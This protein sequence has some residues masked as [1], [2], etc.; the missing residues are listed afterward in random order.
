M[1]RPPSSASLDA[2][3]NLRALLNSSCLQ[4]AEHLRSHRTSAVSTRDRSFQEDSEDNE[5]KPK[6]TSSTSNRHLMTHWPDV[7]TATFSVPLDTSTSVLNHNSSSNIGNAPNNNSIKPLT[8][9]LHFAPATILNLLESQPTST[10][11]N[12]NAA[13]VS[14]LQLFCVAVLPLPA[15]NS[16]LSYSSDAAS[17]DGLTGTN[18]S[19][20]Q[21]S[22]SDRNSS[23][24]NSPYVL[25]LVALQQTLVTRMYRNY[26]PSS[27]NAST[28]GSRSNDAQSQAQYWGALQ[29]LPDHSR[30]R[31]LFTPSSS[32]S[33][34][35]SSSTGV[36]GNN[37]RLQHWYALLADD[38]AFAVTSDTATAS[39]AEDNGSSNKKATAS[40]VYLVQLYAL[41]TNSSNSSNSSNGNNRKVDEEAEDGLQ[42][43]PPVSLFPKNLHY[44]ASKSASTTSGIDGVHFT[45]RPVVSGELSAG[46]GGQFAQDERWF[47]GCVREEQ[48]RHC[49]QP[50]VIRPKHSSNS[51][52][53]RGAAQDIVPVN[54]IVAD[55]LQLQGNANS[56]TNSKREWEQAVLSSLCFWRACLCLSVA[57]SPS[58]AASQVPLCRYHSELRM[59]LDY[60]LPNANSNNSSNAAASSNSESAKYLPKKPPV[61][62]ATPSH[63]TQGNSNP[64]NMNSIAV[65]QELQA[66]QSK[67]D[68]Q[69]L[70]AASTLLQELWDGRLK[71]TVKLF[72]KK[73]AVDMRQRAV[74]EAALQQMKRLL[75]SYKPVEPNAMT[76][77]GSGSSGKQHGKQ[78]SS[79]SVA[80]SINTTNSSSNTSNNF[81]SSN[82]STGA[83]V[84]TLQRLSQL[85]LPATPSWALLR[86]N[87]TI[88][89]KL[90]QQHKANSPGD[91]P[92]T[93][94]SNQQQPLGTSIGAVSA[95]QQQ[96]L[97]F[98]LRIHEIETA[99]SQEIQYFV[100]ELNVFPAVEIAQMR[101]DI[102]SFKDLQEQVLSNNNNNNNNAEDVQDPQYLL[103]TVLS[104]EVKLCERKW[105]LLK[106]RKL[107]EE[108]HRQQLWRRAQRQRQLEEAQMKDPANFNFHTNS[109]SSS[110]KHTRF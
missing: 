9:T 19:W 40:C 101:R 5:R 41:P 63:L 69:L 66:W 75:L 24:S 79:K 33:S 88:N 26:F 105:G 94:A 74:M 10:T 107:A 89:L 35:S 86:Q 109:N 103:L 93:N 81:G 60:H 43:F 32:N 62:P 8:V 2:L 16:V 15:K 92:M 53:S 110:S 95:Q 52:N 80:G 50:L 38:N 45:H 13:E 82:S 96:A 14:P 54:S 34:G 44:N 98:L 91:S 27:S 25:C 23:V 59:S 70:R 48:R 12:Q 58:S 18:T 28:S 20:S 65:L 47:R 49:R 104:E 6:S 7:I 36:N 100:Q 51:F 39:V 78:V 68:L 99:V 30:V 29:L 61:I 37:K 90:Q 17:V 73:V 42:L 84:R 3:Q 22:K 83:D 46:L 1:N 77:A 108:E 72:A 67:R 11:I 87:P 76:V 102:R 56:T 64:S 21:Q 71:Q 97:L 31:Y 57:S 4:V 85:V 55:H 106:Q